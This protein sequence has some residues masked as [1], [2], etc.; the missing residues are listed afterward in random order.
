MRTTDIAL[1]YGDQVLSG[2]IP[3][4]WVD[5]GRYLPLILP[6]K[7][8]VISVPAEA[9]ARAL[10]KPI[11]NAAPFGEL[12]KRCFRGGDVAVLVDDYTRPNNH[13]RL[14]LPVLLGKLQGDYKIPPEKIR[15]VVCAGTHRPPTETEMEKILGRGMAPGLNIVVHNCEENLAPAGEVDGRPISINSVAFNSDIIIPLTDIDNH[16]FAG[17]A[18]GPKAFCP[19]ICN[20]ET[21][22]WEHLH[23]FSKTGFADNVALGILDGN[24]VYECKKRIVSS[25]LA[26]LK[27]NGRGIY[28]LTAIMDPDGDLVYL[29]G[30]EIFAAHRA[31]A[32][33][34]KDIWTAHI[35]ER[36]DVV[37]AGARASGINLYQAGKAVHTA[38]NAVKGG[39]IILT[40]APC[41]D[42]FGNE[43]YKNLMKL[44][45][46]EL[47]KYTDKVKAI[48]EAKFKMLEI[49]RSNFEIGKQKSVDLFRILQFV[50]WGHLHMIQDG[51]SE[52][53]KKLVPFNFYGDS[54]QSAGER[55]LSW[56][57]NYASGKTVGVIDD[58][59]YLVKVQLF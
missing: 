46:A 41:Q 8:R 20:G 4:A 40:A 33:K 10:E 21:V 26:S 6:P 48:R 16:Y 17:V 24:P 34:L 14:L 56:V 2:F 38:Y 59:G 49:V 44:A 37:I 28:C 51:L 53:D 15:I 18:G 39:G 50:G 43:E 11:G 1:H 52:D 47:D 23:M 36:P 57:G 30:G 19:G 5:E 9:L 42:G 35:R 3:Q 29:E 45:A 12:V 13:T 31:A 25:I 22:T 54:D 27:E 32:E 58:P 7:S 55:L